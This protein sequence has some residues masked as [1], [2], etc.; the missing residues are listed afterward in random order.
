MIRLI[1]ARFIHFELKAKQNKNWKHKKLYVFNIQITTALSPSHSL[2]WI[3]MKLKSKVKI[4]YCVHRVKCFHRQLNNN[5]VFKMCN[6][7]DI[8]DFSFPLISMV[9][10]SRFNCTHSKWDG[11]EKNKLI[12]FYF[13]W[14][15][16]RSWSCR[17][18]SWL[19]NRWCWLLWWPNVARFPNFFY[20]FIVVLQTVE[21]HFAFG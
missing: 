12:L 8:F 4:V 21:K 16:R 2:N 5:F 9:Y 6:Y 11:E 19:Q 14:Q 13:C 3:P 15:K 7:V 18:P 1:F 20:P 10:K 17:E